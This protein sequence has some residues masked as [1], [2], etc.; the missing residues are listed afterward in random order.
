MRK[1]KDKERI[2][3]HLVQRLAIQ[4][5]SV[6]CRSPFD[7]ERLINGHFLDKNYKV[8]DLAIATTTFE[9]NPFIVGYID[10][11]CDG[12]VVIREI[13]SDKKC[14]YYNEG[15]YTIDKEKLNYSTMF[16]GLEYKVDELVSEA[17]SGL[18]LK[19]MNARFENGKCFVGFRE[20]FKNDMVCSIEFEY[21]NIPLNELKKIIEKKI[22][23]MFVEYEQE[24]RGN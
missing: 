10:E 22:D 17:S 14:N 4:L 24:L 16:E 5:T 1:L 3:L 8:G 15:F 6:Q 9:P 20:L 2:L 18:Y 19:R 13:G 23:E 12:Y 11:V 7:E 21:K